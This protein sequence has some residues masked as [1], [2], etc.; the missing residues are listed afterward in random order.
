MMF[1]PNLPQ[2]VRAR[3]FIAENGELGILPDDANAFLDAC[4]TDGATVLG[5]ELWVVDHIWGT[6]TNGPV[7]ARRSWCGGVP[8]RGQSLPAVGRGDGDIEETSAQLTA[9]DL[10]A[11]EPIWLPFIR[12]N[13]TLAL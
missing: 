12:I 5:W 2:E 3:A 13:F 10:D 7:P 6:N 4:R 9:L 11:I 8:M 1:P